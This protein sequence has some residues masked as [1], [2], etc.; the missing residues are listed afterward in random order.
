MAGTT[1]LALTGRGS[2]GLC[3][4]E[5]CGR[6]PIDLWRR[7]VFGSSIITTDVLRFGYLLIVVNRCPGSRASQVDHFR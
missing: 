2:H 3:R 6:R 1:T 5:T 7:S 4:E